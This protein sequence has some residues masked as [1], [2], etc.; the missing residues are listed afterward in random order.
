[1]KKVNKIV[2][3]LPKNHFSI[4]LKNNAMVNAKMVMHIQPQSVKIVKMFVVILVSTLSMPKAMIRNNAW[5]TTSVVKNWHF[6]V[7]MM[8]NYVYHLVVRVVKTIIFGDIKVKTRN[9]QKIQ[10]AKVQ[11]IL[12][13]IQIKHNAYLKMKTV[14]KVIINQKI[15]SNA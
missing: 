14:Q 9:V 15:Q 7:Q 1:M 2:H 12:W 8:T 4:I 10:L 3:Q 6:S 13:S 5:L 11:N